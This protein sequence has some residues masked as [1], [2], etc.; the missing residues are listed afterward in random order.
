M[1]TLLLICSGFHQK[2]IQI[3]IAKIYDSAYLLPLRQDT[4]RA[5]LGPGTHTTKHMLQ[6]IG[7]PKLAKIHSAKLCIRFFFFPKKQPRVLPDPRRYLLFVTVLFK[8]NFSV[9]STQ[10]VESGNSTF[11]SLR[12]TEKKKESIIPGI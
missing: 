12:A 3:N 1:P 4:A 7:Q 2:E 8:G 6:N 11:C 5:H 10:I 9:P